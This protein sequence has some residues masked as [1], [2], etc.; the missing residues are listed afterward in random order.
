MSY[1]TYML[2]RDEIECAEVGSLT[3]KGIAES[4]R[5]YSPVR[6]KDAAQAGELIRMT[7]NREIVFSSKILDTKGMSAQEKKSLL[8]SLKRVFASVKDDL[9]G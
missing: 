4:V 9:E 3:L 1:E 2:V 8:L 5:A 7:E 6:I